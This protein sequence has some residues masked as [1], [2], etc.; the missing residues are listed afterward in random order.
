M[1]VARDPDGRALWMGQPVTDI[2]AEWLEANADQAREFHDAFMALPPL[3]AK[4]GRIEY[5]R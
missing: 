3:V 1:R 4:R 5:A 2:T